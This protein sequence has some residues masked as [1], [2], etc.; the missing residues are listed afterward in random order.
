MKG[1]RDFPGCHGQPRQLG[2]SLMGSEVV[3]AAADGDIIMGVHQH[4]TRSYTK[5]Y[6]H[7]YSI[8]EYEGV[9]HTSVTLVFTALK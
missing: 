1:T 8:S 5:S 3:M 2:E 4:R 6:T 9:S 7:M